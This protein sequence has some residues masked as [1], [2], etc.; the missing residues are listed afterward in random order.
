MRVIFL[1]LVSISLLNADFTKS[2][3]V[4]TDSISGLQWQDD[5]IGSS[6]TWESAITYCEDLVL[7]NYSNWRLPNIN[8]LKSIVDRSKRNPAIV[9]GFEKTGTTTPYCS[10]TTFEAKKYEAWIVDFGKGEVIE[11]YKNLSNYYPRC[12]RGG[13]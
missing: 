7:D 6:M 5:A 2:G 4:V 10:S 13:K 12:V 1:I 8:E 11:G 3:N 9:T